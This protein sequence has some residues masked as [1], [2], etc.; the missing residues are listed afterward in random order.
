MKNIKAGA[1]NAARVLYKK[2]LPAEKSYR[3]S[4]QTVLLAENGRALLEHTFTREVTELTAAEYAAVSALSSPQPLSYLEAHGLTELARKRYLVEADHDEAAAYSNAVFLL[5]TMA[6]HAPGLRSY[7]I[8]PTTAC[9]AR[10]VYCF[11]EGF[12]VRTMTAETAARLADFICETKREGKITLR[13]FGGEPLAAV[14]VIR[15]ICE[16]LNGR[17][18][19]FVSRMVTNASLLTKAL[20]HEA[21]ERWHMEYVQVSLDGAKADYTARKRFCNPESDNYESVMQAIQFLADEDIEVML[22]VNVD[23][24]NIS[25]IGEFLDDIAAEFGDMA[26][27]GLYLAQLSQARKSEDCEALQRLIRSFDSRI[28]AMTHPAAQPKKKCTVRTNHCMADSIGESIVILP[29]GTFNHCENPDAS[30]SWGDIFRGVTDPA[31]LERLKKPAETAAECRECP[32]LPE[33]TPFYRHGCR[34]WFKGCRVCKEID[35]EAR[36]RDLMEG[37]N[38]VTDHDNEE[39]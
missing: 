32:F 24:E 5:N 26:H 27:L 31:L 21:K 14:P 13:W 38:T 33:C 19:P 39:L 25:R 6:K 15:Q 11:E 20:A 35:H 36:L 28:R 3:L 22:R 29:D 2:N 9:N 34:E 8:F 16:T 37:V 23:M 10:C 18:V 30:H 4:R 17:G 7:V 1:E 12:A